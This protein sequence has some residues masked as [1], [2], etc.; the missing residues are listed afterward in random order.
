[1][2]WFGFLRSA[3]SLDS[4][5]VLPPCK[6]LPVIPER[7]RARLFGGPAENCKSFTFIT[8]LNICRRR[9][10][11]P[12]TL[13]SILVLQRRQ[14]T[15][16][17]ASKRLRKPPL[18]IQFGFPVHLLFLFCIEHDLYLVINTKNNAREAGHAPVIL[19]AARRV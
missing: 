14:P 18:L 9:R 4:L 11:S 12:A 2:I 7:V 15:S 16:H 19:C 3:G 6:S 1:M 13:F 5:I 8:P 10:T 17:P